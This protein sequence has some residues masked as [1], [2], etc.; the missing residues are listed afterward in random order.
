M[1]IVRN[2]HRRMVSQ[3]ERMGKV[4]TALLLI[5]LVLCTSPAMAQSPWVISASI[6]VRTFVGNIALPPNVVRTRAVMD[7]TR[8]TDWQDA[9]ASWDWE[10]VLDSGGFV[11]SVN[12]Y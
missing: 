8:Q 6:G 9:P 4:K 7:L 1:I 5:A 2:E 3:P 12:V 11:Q 10:K